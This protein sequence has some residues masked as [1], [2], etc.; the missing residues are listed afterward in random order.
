MMTAAAQQY[1]NKIE[2]G[3]LVYGSRVVFRRRRR[4]R[5]H[6][7]DNNSTI[8]KHCH[9]RTH[10]GKQI[11]FVFTYPLKKNRFFIVVVLRG[12]AR[13]P[14]AALFSFVSCGTRRGRFL[15]TIISTFYFY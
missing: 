7:R 13:R 4:R 3:T 6:K 8:Q 15:F 10:G 9:S 12:A 14:G 1:S 5:R 11:A 2:A